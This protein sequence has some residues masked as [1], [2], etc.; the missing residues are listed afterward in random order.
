MMRTISVMDIEVNDRDF[1]DPILELRISCSNTYI[2]EE[3]ETHGSISLGMM[4]F[5]CIYVI[6][7]KEGDEG[8]T[9][10]PG[11]LTQQN[12]VLN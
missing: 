2:I 7:I 8:M 6:I 11:G 5:S 4:A 12:A 1:L 3:A 9:L 10:E